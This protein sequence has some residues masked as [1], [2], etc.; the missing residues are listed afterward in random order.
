M[1][2][3]YLERNVLIFDPDV[4]KELF[5]EADYKTEGSLDTRALSAALS[6]TSQEPFSISSSHTLRPCP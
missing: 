4:L 2:E 5:K 6:G 1:V 3:K